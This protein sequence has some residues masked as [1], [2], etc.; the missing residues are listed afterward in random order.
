MQYQ[1]FFLF[2]PFISS[3]CFLLFLLLFFTPFFLHSDSVV[4]TQ[5]R[6][7]GVEEERLPCG[8]HGHGHGGIH[9]P[10]AT[11]V[12][13]REP[14]NKSNWGETY[15]APMLLFVIGN[16]HTRGNI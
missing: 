10:T 6:A 12:P 7:R 13:Q 2:P 3:F 5:Y 14:A 11:G 8:A 1:L 9:P 16:S 15:A 4:V